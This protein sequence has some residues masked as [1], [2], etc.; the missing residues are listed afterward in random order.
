MYTSLSP[1]PKSIFEP[2]T[3]SFSPNWAAKKTFFKYFHQ[4]VM[5]VV[6]KISDAFR[7]SV[8]KLFFYFVLKI[9]CRDTRHKI[10][11]T[12]PRIFS[13]IFFLRVRTFLNEEFQNA[14]T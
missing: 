13:A 1:T 14:D 6:V 11:K 9:Y 4:Q 2:W 10:Q 12:N 5:D 8:R 7:S 3:E